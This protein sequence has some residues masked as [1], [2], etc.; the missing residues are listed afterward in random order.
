M[1]V[2]AT[3]CQASNLETTMCGAFW[4]GMMVPIVFDEPAALAILVLAKWNSK[5]NEYISTSY[6][7]H[8][9]L[10]CESEILPDG[11]SL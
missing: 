11:F 9:F 4:E 8:P 6:P 3:K 2:A 1:F 5:E 7:R 10:A